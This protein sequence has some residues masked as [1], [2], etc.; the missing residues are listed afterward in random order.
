[1]EWDSYYLNIEQLNIFHIFE[2]ER[3]KK[4]FADLLLVEQ[5]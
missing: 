5:K 2:Y 3:K 4:T 1:M